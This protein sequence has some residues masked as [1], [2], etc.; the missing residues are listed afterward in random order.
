M[1]ATL[2]C[3]ALVCVTS[4][5]SAQ[6]LWRDVPAG[7]SPSEVIRRIAEAQPSDP[8]TLAQTPQAL[9]GIPEVEI[10]GGRF[11]VR[12]LFEDERLQNVVLRAD[13][14]SPEDAQALAR[15]VYT[16]LRARY[17]LEQSSTSRGALA[18]STTMNRRWLFRRTT[19]HLQVVDDNNVLLTYGV[20][21]ARRPGSL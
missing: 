17:G 6:A 7:S 8:A 11:S 1:K 20:Q 16:A 3:L 12:F 15:R 19:V 9:L 21:P 5:A 4:L 18:P 14:G 10:A 13:T 2:L